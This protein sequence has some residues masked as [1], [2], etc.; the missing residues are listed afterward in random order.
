MFVDKALARARE[1]D[2]HFARTQTRVGPCHGLPFSVK[3][4]WAMKG[5]TSST[6][7]AIWANSKEDEDCNIVKILRK[8]GA[9]RQSWSRSYMSA[10][11]VSS[12]LRQNYTAPK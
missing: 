6:G 11:K 1:L 12:I 7:F 2:D 10:I 3:D 5:K 4:Q 8:D 9:G